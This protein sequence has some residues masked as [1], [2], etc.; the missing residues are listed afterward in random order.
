M[1]CIEVGDVE[2][3]AALIRGGPA[4]GRDQEKP[5]IVRCLTSLWN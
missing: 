1:R 4:G 3:V 2:S 5:F